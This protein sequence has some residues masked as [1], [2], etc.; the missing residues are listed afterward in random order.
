MNQIIEQEKNK[1]MGFDD[2][3]ASLDKTVRGKEQKVADLGL[4]L[5]KNN[6]ELEKIKNDKRHAQERVT[7]LTEEYSWVEEEQEYASLYCYTLFE[8]NE[9]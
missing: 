8:Q 4:T 7:E 9:Y 1:L 6:H 2:E 5:Q 3:L